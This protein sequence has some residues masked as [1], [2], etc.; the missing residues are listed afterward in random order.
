MSGGCCLSRG[1]AS[2]KDTECPCWYCA[3]TAE[4]K[5]WYPQPVSSRL[6]APV[7]ISCG[8]EENYFS[9]VKNSTSDLDVSLIDS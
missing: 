2:G 8:Q 5:K 9:A 4:D 1:Y 6:I 3:V 7:Y